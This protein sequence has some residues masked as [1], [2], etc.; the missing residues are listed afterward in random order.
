MIHLTQKQHDDLL[1]DKARLDW[2]ADRN[3]S[4]GNVQLPAE[5]VIK[6]LSSLRG[7]IDD[8]MALS[9]KASA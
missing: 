5:C 8:A 7:A 1:A 3:Q 2:L 6:N 4:I 9:N